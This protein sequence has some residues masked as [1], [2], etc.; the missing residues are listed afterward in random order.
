MNVTELLGRMNAAELLKIV[1]D[2]SDARIGLDES[3]IGQTVRPPTTK[4]NF[5]CGRMHLN[6]EAMQLK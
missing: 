4:V 1:L 5:M 2:R 6:V 3:C